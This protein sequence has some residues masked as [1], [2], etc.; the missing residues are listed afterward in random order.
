[1]QKRAQQENEHNE[2]QREKSYESQGNG[3]I[4]DGL[5]HILGCVALEIEE[6]ADKEILTGGIV[7]EH[8]RLRP[9]EHFIGIL[10][11]LLLG[12]VGNQDV[13]LNVGENRDTIADR[14]ERRSSR[15]LAA[16]DRLGAERPKERFATCLLHGEHLILVPDNTLFNGYEQEKAGERK[17]SRADLEL[18]RRD[19][20]LLKVAK[21]VVLHEG[22][23]GVDEFPRRRRVVLLDKDKESLELEQDLLLNGAVRIGLAQR[24]DLVE[25]KVANALGRLQAKLLELRQDR[26]DG[27]DGLTLATTSKLQFAIERRQVRDVRLADFGLKDIAK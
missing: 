24:L 2:K 14:Q 19:N 16:K 15:L 21:V 9:E 6:F 11:L 23:V 3:R 25:Q 13:A 1:M 4:K 22:D 20:V 18:G 10:E 27:R 26:L 7:H 8:P 17:T 12:H 5:K